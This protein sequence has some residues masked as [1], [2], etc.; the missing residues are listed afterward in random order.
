MVKW[1]TIREEDLDFFHFADTP[2][3]V[4]ECLKQ[5]IQYTANDSAAVRRGN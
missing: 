2:Q 1:G 5:Q 3:K 4:A